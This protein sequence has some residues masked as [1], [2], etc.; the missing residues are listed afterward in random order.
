[1]GV[2]PPKTLEV[3][4]IG[5]DFTIFSKLSQL[6]IFETLPMYLSNHNFIV[7]YLMS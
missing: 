4:F 6:N 3:V 2:D 5:F 1:M 7:L